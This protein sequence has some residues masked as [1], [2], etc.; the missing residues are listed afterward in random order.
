[1]ASTYSLAGAI[2]LVLL[3]SY[4]IATKA[5]R[6][7]ATKFFGIWFFLAFAL[8]ANI[9]TPIGTIMGDRLALVPSIGAIAFLTSVFANGKFASPRILVVAICLFYFSTSFRQVGYW[10][11]NGTLFAAALAHNPENPKALYN[12][13][14]YTMTVIGDTKAAKALFHR[15]LLLVP[16]HL[17]SMKNLADIA[18]REGDVGSVITWYRRILAQYPEEEQVKKQLAE[19]ERRVQ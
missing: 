18:L 11:N 8:T 17:Y 4:L 12:Y 9:I 19:I 2:S 7:A 6:D 3:L 13:G 1:M 10:K 15:V 14:L 16:D 5:S